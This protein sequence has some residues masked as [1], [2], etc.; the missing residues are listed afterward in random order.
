M[1]W[2]LGIMLFFS[3]LL[4]LVVSLLYR[5]KMGTLGACAIC[6]CAVYLVVVSSV[7]PLQA[8]LTGV[9]V[10]ALGVC[11]ARPRTVL[12]STIVC[13]VVSYA[14][15]LPSRLT[16]LQELRALQQLFPEQSLTQRLAYEAARPPAPEQDRLPDE[17]E[18][19]LHEFEDRS[20]VLSTE[21]FSPSQRH[22]RQFMLRMVLHRNNSRSPRASGLPAWI[23][24]GRSILKVKC[25]NYRKAAPSSCRP[26]LNSKRHRLPL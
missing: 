15:Y 21:N 7:L 22:T 25:W 12:I 17:V 9:A 20:G 24:W 13:L 16:E 1:L 6:L 14:L 11:K 19:H 3:L 10:G 18:K 23:S 4:A 26:R 2:T 8:V 5:S